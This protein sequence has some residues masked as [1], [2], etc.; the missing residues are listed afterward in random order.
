MCSKL[1]ILTISV[2]GVVVAV[3]GQE[4]K[5]GEFCV[6]DVLVAG[7]PP[8]KPLPSLGRLSDDMLAI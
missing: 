5:D 3:L 6:K 8:Q 1:M 7:L 2:T 4:E